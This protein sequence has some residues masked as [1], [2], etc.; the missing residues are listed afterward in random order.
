MSISC[1]GYSITHQKGWNHW[2]QAT[3]TPLLS[4]SVSVSA[5]IKNTQTDKAKK[6]KKRKHKYK[7]EPLVK[8]KIRFLK[9]S[10]GVSEKKNMHMR[11][12]IINAINYLKWFKYNLT[13]NL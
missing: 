6:R 12:V 4:V 3:S 7:S 13:V 10:L 8:V 2:P 9:A 11:N 1:C 5:L